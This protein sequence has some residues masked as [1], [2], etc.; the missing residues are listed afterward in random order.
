MK[1]YK[2]ERKKYCKGSKK[3]KEKKDKKKRIFNGGG[4]LVFGWNMNV[5]WWW[6]VSVHAQI[7][8]LDGQ[9]V[10]KSLVLFKNWSKI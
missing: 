10:L 7:L 5:V 3:K 8:R 1:I 6:K 9:K 4:C 2:K